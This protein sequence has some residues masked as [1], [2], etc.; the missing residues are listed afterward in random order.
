MS[1]A[2]SVLSLPETEGGSVSAVD[3]PDNESEE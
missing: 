1:I 2:G 3:V